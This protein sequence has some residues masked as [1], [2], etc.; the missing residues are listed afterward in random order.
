MDSPL[1]AV[2]EP[3]WTQAADFTCSQCPTVGAQMLENLGIL[4]GVAVGIVALILLRSRLT[5]A[6]NRLQRDFKPGVRLLNS[7]RRR[8]SAT[9]VSCG[10]VGERVLLSLA[11]GL[12]YTQAVVR[13]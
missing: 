9:T 10:T 11:S 1:C 3:G 6:F 4:I 7:M 5:A 12:F 2:C 8:W 13:I